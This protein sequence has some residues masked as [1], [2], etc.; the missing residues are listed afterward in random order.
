M[1]PYKTVF[2]ILTLISLIPLHSWAQRNDSSSSRAS[3]EQQED[4]PPPLPKTAAELRLSTLGDLSAWRHKEARKEL[5]ATQDEFGSTPEF[6]TAW[7]YLLAEEKKLDKAVEALAQTTKANRI[8]PA[9]AWLLGEIYSWKKEKS[10][11]SKA[12]KDAKNRAGAILKDRPE[13]GEANY[14]MGAALLKL[15]KIAEAGK[16]LKKAQAKG[17]SPALTK[18]QL[19]LYFSAQKKWKDAKKAFDECIK[20][21]SGFAH[22]YYYRARVLDKLGQK[23]EMLIDLDRF[24]KL[25]PDA[26]EAAAAQALLNNGG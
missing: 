3:G 7:G 18:L 5:I 2:I 13:D 20:T 25:A 16:Y 10:A 14:W 9:P 24:V 11:A 12:F 21:D 26:R 22:A 19:G 23:S 17:F 6:K 1:R 4:T 8:D 15:G